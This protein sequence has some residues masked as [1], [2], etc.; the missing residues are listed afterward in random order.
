MNQLKKIIMNI[1]II[2]TFFDIVISFNPTTFRKL[3]STQKIS[4]KV[5]SSGPQEIISSYYTINLKVYINDELTTVDSNNKINIL[6][7]NDILTLQWDISLTNCDNMFSGLSNIIEIDLTEFD[8]SGIT[9]MKSFLENCENLRKII[10]SENFRISIDS[11]HNFFYNC[12]SLTSL[13]LSFFE[14]SSVTS[15]DNMFNNCTSLTNII[16]SNSFNTEK[17]TNM[18]KMFYKCISLSSLDLSVFNT[19]KVTNFNNIF[20]NCISLINLNIANFNT[21]KT[22]EMKFMFNQCQ[23][24]T[25]LD[26]THFNTELVQDMNEMFSG[27]NSLAFLDISSFNTKNVERMNKMFKNCFSLKSLDVSNFDTSKATLLESFFDGCKV[28]TSIDIS[29]FNTS[30]CTSMS[31]MFSNCEMLTSI[32]IS[33]FDTTKVS[34]MRNMFNKCRLITSLD[35][36]NFKTDSVVSLEKMFD[37][38]IS[39]KSLNLSNFNTQRV[40]NMEKMFS[41]CRALTSL[42][43]S[44]FNTSLVSNFINMF[45]NCYQLTSL[46]LKSFDTSRI[47]VMEKMFFNCNSIVSLDLSNFN[48]SLV[49]NMISMFEGCSNLKYINMDNFEENYDLN[50]TNIFENTRDDLIYCIGN[51]NLTPNIKMLLYKKECQTL[52]C[53]INWEENYENFIRNKKKDIN[54]IYDKCIVKSFD[55]IIN[56]FYF[57]NEIPGVSIYIYN[58][59]NVEEL[60]EKYYNLTFIEL[61][62][63]QKKELLNKFGIEENE[64]LYVFISDSPSND[65]NQATSDYSYAFYLENGTQLNISQISEEFTI[66]ITTPIRNLSLAN[67]GY[68]LEFSI[69]GYDIYNI[70]GSF[71]TDICSSASTDNNDITL[72]DRKSDIYPNNIT[73]C[74]NNCE[75]QEVNLTEKRLICICNLNSYD[76][77]KSE[78]FSFFGETSDEI[79]DYFLD[80]INYKIFNC[81][82]LLLSFDNLIKNP[83]F[84]VIIIIFII[85][86]I[87]TVIFL[88]VGISNIR[89]YMHKEI[90]TKLKLRELIIEHLKEMKKKNK[91]NELEPPKK[92]IE[93]ET[94]NNENCK[95]QDCSKNAQSVQKIFSNNENNI[96]KK[97]LLKKG[98]NIKGKYVDYKMTTEENLNNMKKNKESENKINSEEK[99]YKKDKKEEIIIYKKKI[100]YNRVPF[101]QAVRE[102]KRSLCQLIK[103]LLFEKIGLLNIFM[104]HQFY[105][106]IT[107]SQYLLSL[108][109]DFFFNTLF[110]SDEIISHKYH[111]NGRLDFVITLI[112]SLIANII[113]SI[114]VHFIENTKSIEEKLEIIQ[115][116]KDEKRYL[117]W[118]NKYIKSLKNKIVIFI[119]IELLIILGAFYYIAIF[120]IVYSHSTKSLLINYVVSLLESLLISTVI[121][122]IIVVMRK[123]GISY[124]NIYIYNTSKFIDFNF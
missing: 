2:I 42:D 60:K 17:V 39:L 113:T 104:N 87:Y 121:S 67:Y 91:N 76:T 32:D 71:Y 44:N 93:F 106:T 118:S 5:L 22:V 53:S 36:S 1:F 119:I 123:I 80:K 94:I 6:D 57:S 122:G 75:Y 25:S 62:I 47:T 46:D 84:Y 64:T 21:S 68:A 82:H 103:S 19:P 34:N 4:L 92:K 16:F 54:I 29:H 85:S 45:Y 111:N 115:E 20:D 49:N 23:S 41:N 66:S 37:G 61:T 86:I 77:N 99:I 81:Y 72:K 112:L 28:L 33:H 24:L 11:T 90:P 56:D 83:P 26:L 98:R 40:M 79:I 38:C 51:E 65:T 116:V 97:Y 43:I 124:Q 59:E 3:Q 58:L 50:S 70:S 7:N 55:N 48:T 8:S 69:D 105:R 14:T 114:C 108:L 18:E 120:F 109:L 117:F 101:S 10:F 96:K 63:E 88:F 107:I 110:Y 12:H 89:I 35:F 95:E 15:M 31:N 102:D 9:S 100:N 27:C 74:Q 13:D 30:S 78:A 52:D 73:L